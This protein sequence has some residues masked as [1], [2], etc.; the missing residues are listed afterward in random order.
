MSRKRALVDALTLLRQHRVC[1]AEIA[2]LLGYSE[3]HVRRVCN[4]F[5]IE[6]PPLPDSLQAR[7][8]EVR[9]NRG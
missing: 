2:E 9:R 6:R 5:G 7:I 8:A 3:T 1:Y 4:T